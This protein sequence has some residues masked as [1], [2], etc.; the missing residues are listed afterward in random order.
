MKEDKDH[1]RES[2]KSILHVKN[3]MATEQQHIYLYN[4]IVF[5]YYKMSPLTIN[6]CAAVP[7]CTGLCLKERESVSE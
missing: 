6:L 7:T 5:G 2:I 1:S 3:E 4:H